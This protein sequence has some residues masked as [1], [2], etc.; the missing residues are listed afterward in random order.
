MKKLE[1]LAQIF[2]NYRI[3]PNQCYHDNS[4]VKIFQR[5]FPNNHYSKDLEI[6]LSYQNYEPTQRGADLPFWGKEYFTDK[7]DFRVLIVGQ[8]SQCI[9]AGSIILHS[10]LMSIDENEYANKRSFSELNKRSLTGLNERKVQLTEWGIDF[11]FLYMTDASKVYKNGSWKNKN[12]DKE[13][14]KELLEAE[15]EFCDPNLIILLGAPALNLLDNTK[16]Y[17]SVVISG[18]YIPIKGRCCVV[19]PFLGGTSP[20]RSEYKDGLKIATRLIKEKL[21]K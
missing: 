8:D 13:K 16:K 10:N 15:I 5:D 19:S 2:A 18:E 12:F 21:K 3:Y 20:C 9:D 4:R 7:K 17:A 6:L 1:D 11:N 14:S